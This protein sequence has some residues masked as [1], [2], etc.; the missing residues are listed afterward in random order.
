MKTGTKWAL[1]A[2]SV[3]M[4]LMLVFT[5]PASVMK[6]SAAGSNKIIA[7]YYASWSAYSGY[8]PKKIPASYLTHIIYA[9]ANISS[10]YKIALGDPDV[11]PGNLAELKALKT[12]YP[13]LKTLISVGGWD[14]SDKFSDMASASSRRTAFANSVAAFLKKYGLDGVDLDWE[15]PVGGGQAGNSARAA[16]KTN[17]TL[18]LKALR[19]KLNAQGKADGKAYLLTIAGGA[20]KSYISHVQMSSI[21]KYVN[22]ATVMTYDMHGSYD[23]YTDHNAPLYP[24]PGSPQEACSASQAVKAWTAAGFPK[25]KLVMGV[26][27]YGHLYSGVKGGGTGIFKTYSG[28]QFLTYDQIVSKYLPNKAYK[29]YYGA[30]GK[31]PWLFNGSNFITY[32]DARSIAA[33][34][35]Y[36][37]SMGIAGAGIW[38]LSQNTNGTLLKSLYR[39]LK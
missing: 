16:D 27:F 7:G 31:T 9:F 35:A 23:K 28:M 3:A 38:E 29:R 15:Y 26:P 8:T 5:A 24:A 33:K 14:W 1:K 20:D 12:K 2:F 25:S 6:A 32:E 34:D 13:K 19:T 22:F 21:A 11:D 18:L 17:F 36:I 37:K 10:S 4:V 39:G 30:T